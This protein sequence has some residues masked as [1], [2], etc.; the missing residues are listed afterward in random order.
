MP[1]VNRAFGAVTLSLLALLALA[2][3]NAS[4]AP[5]PS[6]GL[7]TVLAKPPTSDFTELTSA[8]IRGEFTAHDWAINATGVSAAETEATLNRHGFVDGYG[9][10]W[11]SSTAR[12]AL[13]EVVMAFTGGQG[14][15]TILTDFEKSAK[16]DPH[17]QHAETL[18]G[19]DP[20]FGYR[21]FDATSR[22]YVVGF[23][24]VKGNDLFQVEFGSTKDDA[25]TPATD[26]AKVQYNSA[27]N[28][29][30]PTSEWPENT[31]SSTAYDAGRASA[32]VFVALIVLGI[33]AFVAR[34]VIR[35]R[36]RTAA[37]HPYGGMGATPTV[38]LSPDGNYWWDGQTWRDAASQ[39][40]PLAQR[41]SDGTLW[42]DGRTWRPVPPPYA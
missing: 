17:Y 32:N 42:W 25:L 27:P 2:P 6:P 37:G 1:R 13:F 28:S 34:T 21:A 8:P 14:A 38:Q 39:A 40:P 3:L 9:K 41:S 5:S 29:T 23:A 16:S 35:G 19:I 22:S 24:F 20:S 36:R 15:R 26:Q 33:I 18:A 7:D 10:E 30:I 11:A 4:A 31:G 12:H